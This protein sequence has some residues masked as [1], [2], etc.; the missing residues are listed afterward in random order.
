MIELRLLKGRSVKLNLKHNIVHI[1]FSLSLLVFTTFSVAVEPATQSAEALQ[2]KADALGK[3]TFKRKNGQVLSYEEIRLLPQ[4]VKDEIFDNEMTDQEFDG[5]SNWMG[6]RKSTI[7]ARIAELD[8]TNA[9]IKAR[10]AEKKKRLVEKYTLYIGN[11]EILGKGSKKT[12]NEIINFQ[13][14]PEALKQ[15]TRALLANKNM[16]WEED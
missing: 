14:T 3:Q 12:F 8:K 5:Y 16:Q 1:L 11:T 2:A 10:N 7:D 13:E 9:E 6:V 4:N 15:R